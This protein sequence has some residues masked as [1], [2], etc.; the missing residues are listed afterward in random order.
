MKLQQTHWLILGVFALVGALYGETATS[1]EELK[2]GLQSAEVYNWTEAVPHLRSAERSAKPGDRH[3]ATF[4]RI[5]LM[6]AT[7]EQHNLARLTREYEALTQ[8]QVVRTDGQVRMWLY[9]AKG[10]CDNDLQYPEVARK[11][12]EQVQQLAR[13]VGDDKWNYR[14]DGELAIPAYYLGDL[15][16]SRKLVTQALTAAAAAKDNASV[17]RLLTHIGT[18]YILREQF[19]QGMQH[20]AKA[21]QLA[22]LE[23]AIGYPAS[24][25]EGQVLG[26][27]G[28]GRL[29]EAASL[30]NEIIAK[31]QSEDRRIHEAQTR[32]MLATIYELQKNIPAA[33]RELLR[34]IQMSAA[35]NYY[36]PLAN[37]QMR[38][39]RLY[40]QIG[41]L[42]EA[43]KYADLALTSTHNSGIVSELPNRLEFLATLKVSQGK[44]QQAISLY[45]EAEDQVDSQLA[46]TPM[47]AKH[48]LLKS[49]SDV[50][51]DLFALLAEH[52]PS[53][54]GEY[55]TVER[56][57]GR[58]LADLLRSGPTPSAS[59]DATEREI[60]ELRLQLATATSVV[61]LAKA[62]DAIFFAQHKRWL[63]TSSEAGPSLRQRADVVLPLATVQK[64][65]HSTEAIV[66]YVVTA[67]NVYGVII[68]SKTAR[69]VR[70]GSTTAINEATG[71]FLSAVRAKESAIREGETLYA[72]LFGPISEVGTHSDVVIVPDGALHAVP[73]GALVAGGKRFVET[74]S[75]M[76]ASSASTHIRLRLRGR[77]ADDEGLLAVG[78]VQYNADLTR[79]AQLRGFKGTLS[80]LPGSHEEAVGAADILGKLLKRP[81][82]LDGSSATETAVLEALRGREVVHLAVHGVSRT[83]DDPEMA[84]LLFLPDPK[85]EKDGLL[86][87]SEIVRLNLRSDLVVLSACDTAAGQVQGE[88][89]V[90]NL[91]RAFLL[92]GARTVV[93]TL[94]S[95]DDAF[96]ATLMQHFYEALGGGQTKSAA[97]VEAQRYVIGHFGNTA[98]PWYW[99]GYVLEGDATTPLRSFQHKL[100]KQQRVNPPSVVASANRGK[101]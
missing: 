18:V 65:L 38:L 49:T 37:A 35:G 40:L 15:A 47:F 90:A 8:N 11:D 44:F 59:G 57:R 1:I 97:L 20:L 50:Y 63:D 85:G 89:G 81:L 93:S 36:D 24:V 98:V 46:L 2:K 55:N 23:P 56:V 68:T 96:S 75:I 29:D 4:A 41:K 77:T 26:L 14:A 42:P 78:G 32:V 28:M 21:A 34:A 101:V 52:S 72:L 86:E 7:M 84:A 25:K 100:L 13:S 82:V 9:I 74:H 53:T 88:E 45:K 31:M 48:L 19:E 91:S 99:A 16:S 70:L 6:R 22:S 66:E 43:E 17:V 3:S 87:I 76:R 92:G 33:I 58:V 60:N 83:D 79:I 54:T 95:V 10:D 30:A 39:S 12:W 73:F 67:S 62:R 51:T 94:W 27:I 69:V 61:Q 80:N 71:R 5:L 64:Y